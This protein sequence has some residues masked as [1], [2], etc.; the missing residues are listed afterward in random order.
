MK[1]NKDTSVI[2]K[3]YYCHGDLSKDENGEYIN[4]YICPYWSMDSSKP[5][6]ACG[7]CSYLE[8]GDWDFNKEANSVERKSYSKGEDGKFIETIHPPGSL[9]GTIMEHVGLLW[10]YC[11]EC[12]IKMEDP[13]WDEFESEWNLT[14]EME[15]ME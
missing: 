4:P 14:D 13:E 7:Y 6:Q 10:D 12:N 8:K 11:K 15:D 1:C 9:E 2:P 5:E 3:G